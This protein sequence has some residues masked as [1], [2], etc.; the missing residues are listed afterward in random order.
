MASSDLKSLRARVERI[1]LRLLELLN[2]RARVVLAINALKRRQGIPP[3]VPER[4]QK[5]LAALSA[6]NRGPFSDET[7]RRL[8]REVFRASLGL[9]EREQDATYRI[10]RARRRGRFTFTVGGQTVG[11]GPILI[12]GPCSVESPEQM[13][14]A[15]RRLARLGVRFLRGGAFKPRSS[16]YSFQGLG[17]RGLE[18]LHDVGRRH[19][20]VTVTEVVDTRAVETVV[21]YADVVQVGARN[22]HNY[23]LLREVGRARVPVLLKR[24]LAATISEFLGSAEYIAA[25]GNDRII[26]CERGIRTFETQTR[27]TLDIAAVPL[28]RQQSYLPV[29]VDVSHAAG[30]TDILAPLA[31]AA[32][33]AGANG[34]MVEVHPSPAVARS[35]PEQ[36]LDLDQFQRFLDEIGFPW[37]ASPRRKMRRFSRGKRAARGRLGELRSP[38]VPPLVSTR[39]TRSTGR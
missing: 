25:E 33:A 31:C 32:L 20:L 35:D 2:Q 22:M 23:E 4:E 38:K 1:N 24:G 17:V 27:N 7:V 10:S 12:A 30:R 37:R 9:M 39:T 3:Y 29:I 34:V 14:L 15:A 8:F 26:L 28:L 11:A 13:E 6:R 16:P 36:Q 5:M 19:G 18:I 21:R